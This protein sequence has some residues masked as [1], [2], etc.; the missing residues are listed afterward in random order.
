M[1]IELITGISG[2]V[3]LVCLTMCPKRIIE[4]RTRKEAKA[5]VR[6]WRRDLLKQEIHLIER[7]SWWLNL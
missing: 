3:S 5:A 4:W 7:A 2:I 1:L 6:G